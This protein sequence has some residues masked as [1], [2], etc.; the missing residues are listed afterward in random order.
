[1]NRILPS[2]KEVSHLTSQAMDEALPFQT[3]LA[4]RIHIRMCQWCRRNAEQLQLMRTLA[5]KKASSTN[6]P[7]RLSDEARQRL[8]DALNQNHD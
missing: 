4:M 8:N 3:R 2:C 6:E 7:P 1:M 5:R